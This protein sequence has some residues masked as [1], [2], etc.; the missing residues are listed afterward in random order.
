MGVAAQALLVL[1]VVAA[2]AAGSKTDTFALDVDGQTAL[3]EV[4]ERFVN[5]NVRE[6]AALLAQASWRAARVPVQR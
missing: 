6:G 4:D 2:A 3:H 1:S 5:F